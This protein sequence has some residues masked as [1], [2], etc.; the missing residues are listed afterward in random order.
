MIYVQVTQRNKHLH[1]I[2][3][4]LKWIVMGFNYNK[5][6]LCCWGNF[7]RIYPA[8]E[9]WKTRKYEIHITWTYHLGTTLQHLFWMVL[10][11]VTG[12]HLSIPRIPELIIPMID[13]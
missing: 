12:L 2:D 4:G 8:M 11:G 6:G 3:M 13:L 5:I 10:Y 7:N 9:K 1:W